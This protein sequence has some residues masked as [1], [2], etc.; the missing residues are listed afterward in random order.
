MILRR[1][2]S[3]GYPLHTAL[4]AVAALY[5]ITPHDAQGQVGAASRWTLMG[6][7][8]LAPDRELYF[9]TV[10][11]LPAFTPTQSSAFSFPILYSERI[12]WPLEAWL[13]LELTRNESHFLA[14]RG[15]WGRATMTSHVRGSVG[16]YP[17]LK[18]GAT[19]MGSDLLGGFNLGSGALRFRLYTGIS[20]A[21]TWLREGQRPDTASAVAVYFSNENNSLAIRTLLPRQQFTARTTGL[22]VGGELRAPLT[23]GFA[24]TLG[25][26]QR[27]ERIDVRRMADAHQAELDRL[28]QRATVDYDLYTSFPRALTLGVEWRLSTRTKP[29]TRPLAVAAVRGLAGGPAPGPDAGAVA[30]WRQTLPAGVR[31]ALAATDTAT[32]ITLLEHETARRSADPLI[33]GTLGILLAYTAGELE[34]DFAQRVRARSLLEQALSLDGS[35]PRHLLALAVVLGKQLLHNEARRMLDRAFQATVRRPAEMD[36]VELADAFFRA[37]TT[38]E[39]QLL[40]FELLRLGREQS[41][42]NPPIT[43]L[44]DRIRGILLSTVPLNHS[45]C[46]GPFCLNWIQPRSFL[47]QF[48]EL[49]DFSS[50][51]D[52]LRAEM[53]EMFARALELAP[54]HDGAHR[55]T[56]AAWARLDSWDEVL[57][58]ARRYPDVR[59]EDPWP[60]LFLASASYWRGELASADS[61]FRQNLNRLA[62]S[63]LRMFLDLSTVLHAA[64]EQAW[65]GMSEAQQAVLRGVYWRARD[66]LYLTER[67][68]REAEHAA[69]V[70]LAELLFGEPQRGV[71]GWETDRGQILIRYGRPRQVWQV[72]RRDDQIV[73]IVWARDFWASVA[74]CYRR[75]GGV[76][77]ELA[78]CLNGITIGLA[79]EGIGGGRWI[80]WNYDPNL[81]SF[82]FEKQLGRATVRHMARSQSFAFAQDMKALQPALFDSPFR[83]AGE[84]T[85]QAARFR[86][87]DPDRQEVV[88]YGQAPVAGLATAP[89]DT[90]VRGL[91]LHQSDEFR[92]VARQTETS[93]I[94]NGEMSYR[95]LVSPGQYSY[96]LEAMTQ[97]AVTATSSRGTIEIESVRPGLA[98]SDLLLATYATRRPGLPEPT[99]ARDLDLRPLRCMAIP[100][101]RVLAF[102]F[103]IYGLEQ[104]AG[105]TRYRVTLDT[106]DIAAPSVVT[107]LLDGLRQ[108]IS[109]PPNP[110]GKL[111]FERETVLGPEQ[112]R[113]VD[114]FEIT[115]PVGLEA[116]SIR[117]GVTVTDLTTGES[118]RAERHLPAHG[119]RT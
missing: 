87:R 116:E 8:S 35:N 45:G 92:Q 112:D 4:L 64:D 26:E 12:E 34:T 86:G 50:R 99:S 54:D 56:L 32:A 30:D 3:K 41:D 39:Q 33:M 67:N 10:R 31:E 16:L 25:L 102:A 60:A 77:R 101:E 17:D 119:C 37:G 76:P 84:L 66:P 117:F 40:D 113:I 103:E 20:L 58:N 114:W 61:L 118:V 14:L 23:S 6:G 90:V 29:D 24:M 69:R 72:E 111:A 18:A 106:G 100:V 107:R 115:L 79:L 44:N 96:A 110:D 73:D 78:D 55:R 93:S 85:Y 75:E 80:F 82:V 27:T 109:G 42:G 105:R 108:L 38:L 70:A 22:V 89:S 59:P 43:M 52:S 11:I 88:F 68:E 15:R 94:G 104:V 21:S 51:A 48:D 9:G 47:S 36:L 91:V 97:D 83:N 2:G 63:D 53:L 62:P 81:P 95:V 7:A 5:L 28:G 65:K 98:M 71:R 49:P 74:R 57:V 1:L 46:D 13:R 19:W